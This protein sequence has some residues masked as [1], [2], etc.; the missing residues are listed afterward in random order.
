MPPQTAGSG[1]TALSCSP[2]PLHHDLKQHFQSHLRPLTAAHPMTLHYSRPE[3]AL[4]FT[5]LCSGTP[6]ASVQDAFPPTSLPGKVP[7]S[8]YDS[9]QASLCPGV[10]PT[11]PPPRYVSPL[12]P[13]LL[14]VSLPLL[15]TSD[16][17]SQLDTGVMTQ[18][19][20]SWSTFIKS[21]PSSVMPCYNR[22]S[23]KVGRVNQLRNP[24]NRLQAPR[25]FSFP[26][27]KRGDSVYR[28]G[29]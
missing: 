8:H 3:H 1:P 29:F 21:L 17:G 20:A 26:L 18:W 24:G 15:T 28:A 10:L 11:P 4:S 16:A 22:R 14:H 5:P 27:P 25:A 9:A 7:P 19:A 13:V 6:C 12:P 23:G 2:K